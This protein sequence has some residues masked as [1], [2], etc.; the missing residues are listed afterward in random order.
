MATLTSP[1]IQLAVVPFLNKKLAQ[2]M[3]LAAELIR[4]LLAEVG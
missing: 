3:I 4:Q 1:E 2:Q